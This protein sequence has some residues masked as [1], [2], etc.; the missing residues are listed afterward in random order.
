MI[1]ILENVY[2][3]M[4]RIDNLFRTKRGN[5][6][7]IYF[8]AGYPELNSTTDIIRFLSEG[9]ADMIEIGIPF[10]DPLADGPIIQ[11][12]NDSALRNGMS[13]KTLFNQLDD[14]R[15]KVDIPLLLMGYLNPI[16]KFGMEE[17]CR[18]C[19]DTGIDGVIVPDLPPEVYEKK[20]S[21]IFNEHGLYNILLISPLTS[22]ERIAM[23]DRISRGFI[24]MVSSSSTTGIKKEFS[25]VRKDY[26]RRVKE[27]KLSNPCL[28][29]FGI[30][31][32]KTFRQACEMA[33]GAIVGSAFI[34][35]LAEKG[36]S[37]DTIVQF[38]REIKG[39]KELRT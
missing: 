28:I 29:G 10:S 36:L 4:N 26:F 7:S 35:S 14:I 15:N 23:A 1:V 24:Y 31:D 13:M 27:M 22:N 19:H 32:N 6:L 16:L 21:A 25:E 30:S 34:R 8:T 20:Y 39:R 5:I 2:Y 9:G 3:A 11:K 37:R 12:S 38:I 17:F 33:D 18:K